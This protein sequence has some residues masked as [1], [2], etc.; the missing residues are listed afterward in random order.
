MSILQRNSKI[1]EL[2]EI[3]NFQLMG[4]DTLRGMEV[5]EAK[6]SKCLELYN[7]GLL[8]LDEAKDK[9]RRG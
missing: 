9:L 2:I 3:K 7:A 6:Y 8:T 4:T 1:R 5:I